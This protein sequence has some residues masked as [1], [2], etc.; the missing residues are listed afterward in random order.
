MNRRWLL[1]SL[2]LL[3]ASAL[4]VLAKDFVRDHIVSPLLYLLWLLRLELESL[5]QSY[6]WIALLAVGVLLAIRSLFAG[7]SPRG[8]RPPLDWDRG[9]PVETLT[10]WVD[11]AARSDYYK[12]RIA[13][14]LGELTLEALAQ[15]QRTS[16]DHI[17]RQLD[18]GR[19]DAPP[20]VQAYLRAGLT[21]QTLGDL[22]ASPLRARS[23]PLDLDPGAVVQFLETQLE[24]ERDIRHR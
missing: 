13:Q 18:A 20:D 23:T 6:L 8:W 5:P 17:Q 9:G 11:L 21:T 2:A 16:P 22:S 4:A 15:H 10:R 19:L 12:W 14:R 24:A 1:A 7:A 3:T